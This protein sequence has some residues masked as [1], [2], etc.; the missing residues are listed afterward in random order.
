[1]PGGGYGG[2]W[3]G[4]SFSAP[5]VAA[6]V[7]LL[8]ARFEEITLAGVADRLARTSVALEGPPGAVQWGRLDAGGA[9]RGGFA[10]LWW[11]E[12]SGA[13]TA[14]GD[15]VG[16]G[17]LVGVT[18]NA[19]LRAMGA[20][21]AGRGYWLGSADGGVFAFG[22]AGFFGS[23]GGVALNSPV[24]G[25]AATPSGRGYWLVAADGGVFAFGDAPFRGAATGST[26]PVVGLVAAPGGDGY[27]VV[28]RDGTTLALGSAPAL[29]SSAGAAGTPVVAVTGAPPVP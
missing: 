16:R 28:S 17:S 22:D 6:T 15:A 26:A 21:P 23:L 20:T 13:V 18:T 9:L 11:V 2:G 12:A 29:G 14:L 7:A 8:R 4:T 24:V 10:G 25:M 3:T 19:P 27:W 5:L 1:V